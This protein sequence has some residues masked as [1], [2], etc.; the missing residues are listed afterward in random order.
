MTIQYFPQ[1]RSNL[2]QC[3]EFHLVPV[4]L[5]TTQN[6]AFV[7]CHPTLHTCLRN[8]PTLRL[9]LLFLCVLC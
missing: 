5:E 6:P 9:H 4:L 7:H 8:V 1:G 2:E 3:P